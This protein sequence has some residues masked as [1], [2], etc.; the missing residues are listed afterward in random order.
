MVAD[1]V[2]SAHMHGGVVRIPLI[3]KILLSPEGEILLKY[4]VGKVKVKYS[5]E[6]KVH[7][8]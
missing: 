2:L 3:N 6:W 1:L 4:D 7:K 5:I 8:L